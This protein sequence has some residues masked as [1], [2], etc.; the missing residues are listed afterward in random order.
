MHKKHTILVIDDDPTELDLMTR[1]LSAAGYRVLVAEDG[2]SGANYAI[3]GRPD[4][5]LLD[6]MMPGLNGYE[7]CAEL[8]SNNRTRN[9]PIFFK[10]CLGLKQTTIVE[11]FRA[12]VDSII[13]KPCNHEQLL[14]QI[15]SRLA[16]AQSGHLKETRVQ[17][18][19]R[20]VCQELPAA[21]FFLQALNF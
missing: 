9:I 5:I 17:L 2:E 6:V 18:L 7:T 15:N 10:T 16:S 20:S 12:G 14:M 21:L 19:A 3:F 8:R 13:T 4:L 1:V 11:G